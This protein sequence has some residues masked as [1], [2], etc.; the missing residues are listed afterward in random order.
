[1]NTTTSSIRDNDAQVKQRRIEH[2]SL[3]PD[4]RRKLFERLH[5]VAQACHVNYATSP[6]IRY[7]YPPINATILENMAACLA[8]TPRFYVQTLHLMNKM[9]L[10]C[11]LVGYV[12]QPCCF[13]TA[14]AV[15]SGGAR[16]ESIPMV[17]DMSSSSAESELELDDSGEKQKLTKSTKVLVQSRPKKLKVKS[18]KPAAA[19]ATATVTETALE[20]QQVFETASLATSEEPQQYKKRQ[21]SEQQQATTSDFFA[22]RLV[23]ASEFEGFARVAPITS[24]EQANNPPLATNDDQSATEQQFDDDKLQGFISKR[25]LE[26]NRL[27]LSEMHDLA[28]FKSYERGEATSRLYIKNVARKATEAD[29]RFIYGRYVD[30]SSEQQSAS[31]DIRLM[32]EGRMK[33][34]AFVTLANETVASKALAETNGYM[35]HDK[36]LVVQFARSAKPK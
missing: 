2:S 29:I 16:T 35:L 15:S 25:Q 4:V 20:R 18:F 7:E 34:Q 22:N 21:Q 32:T 36:P 24:S 9:N 26:E 12:R 33:G 30:W 17:I 27:R 31:F 10:P 6:R 1:M 28:V 11:P 23:L 5:G 19:V 8:T 14:A 3:P 13:A